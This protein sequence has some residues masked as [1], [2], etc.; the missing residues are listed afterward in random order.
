MENVEP[1]FISAGFSYVHIEN[2]V[3]LYSIGLDITS[4]TIPTHQSRITEEAYGQ[5]SSPVWEEA[6]M[7]DNDNVLVEN[8]EIH[9]SESNS[10]ESGN[11]EESSGD[12][13]SS[14]SKESKEDDEDVVEIE[15]EEFVDEDPFATPN[16][17]EN[18]VHRFIATFVVMF[19]S[20]YVVNKSAVV[21]IEFI[22]KLLTI[23]E[24]DF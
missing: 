22:N 18:S 13:E 21:L 6:P 4:H 8:E 7:S 15:V 20:R 16:I 14:N 2:A 9:N 12:D 19:A 5:T 3:L 10:D 1:I 17:P 23:Y 11:D 24:Q